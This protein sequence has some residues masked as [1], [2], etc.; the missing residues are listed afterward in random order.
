MESLLEKNRRGGTSKAYA[1]MLLFLPLVYHLRL[2]PIPFNYLFGFSAIFLAILNRQCAGKLSV[3]FWMLAYFFYALATLFAFTLPGGFTLTF[4]KKVATFC[5]TFMAYYIIGRQILD[6]RFFIKGYQIICGLLTFAIIL[7]FVCGLAGHPF[8]MLP[9]GINL[10]SGVT[11]AEHAADLERVGRYS[12]VFMEPAHQIQYVMPCLVVSLFDR[13]AK[14]LKGLRYPIFLSVGII[15]TTSMQ[16]ILGLGIIWG[17]YLRGI[18][19]EHDKKAIAYLVLLSPVLI[20]ALNALLSSP[21]IQEQFYK[22]IS[23]VGA[24]QNHQYGSS[25]FLRVL[26]GWFCYHDFDLF[27]KLFGCGYDN[28]REYIVKTGIAQKYYPDPEIIGYMNG[29]TL[30]LCQLGIVGFLLFFIFFMRCIPKKKTPAIKAMLLWW[31]IVMLTSMSLDST[32][33]LIPMLLMSAV[34]NHP[35]LSMRLTCGIC[36]WNGFEGIIC[37]TDTKARLP[38]A[39]L[40]GGRN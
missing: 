28:V 13:N 35:A 30:L 15:A 3:D 1:V 32:S 40:R 36:G 12:T 4:I 19:K 9:P 7:Q 21:I 20:A 31:L 38:V 29:M 5:L 2:L 24:I 8:S 14:G 26:S 18:L 11:S 10:S 6:K 37:K 23:S 22:K 33:S 27:H 17:F 34:E 39:Q 25:M 16:G